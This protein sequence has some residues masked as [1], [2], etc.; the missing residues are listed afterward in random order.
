VRLYLLSTLVAAGMLLAVGIGTDSSA[1]VLAPMFGA[2]VFMGA[3]GGS[4]RRVRPIA[5]LGMGRIRQHAWATVTAWAVVIVM[6]AIADSLVHQPSGWLLVPLRRG[7]RDNDRRVCRVRGGDACAIQIGQHPA[8]PERY[9]SP[10]LIMLS[11]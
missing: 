1:V 3:V 6:G 5:P 2:A 7:N 11:R 4:P 9:R 10:A 8:R